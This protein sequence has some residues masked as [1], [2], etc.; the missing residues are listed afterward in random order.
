[1]MHLE[2]R[3]YEKKI[4]FFSHPASLFVFK[5]CEKGIAIKIILNSREDTF[6]SGVIYSNRSVFSFFVVWLNFRKKC[7]I[8]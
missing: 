7:F 8:S 4:V 5:E 6:V 1:M 3:N 2:S